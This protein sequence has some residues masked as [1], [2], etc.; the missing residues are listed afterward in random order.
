MR[1]KT[2]LEMIQKEV[3]GRVDLGYITLLPFLY[4]G[5]CLIKRIINRPFSRVSVTLESVA[6]CNSL[7]N[8]QHDKHYILISGHC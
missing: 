2:Q 6:L 1:V 4:L 5:V 7:F 8:S 3:G